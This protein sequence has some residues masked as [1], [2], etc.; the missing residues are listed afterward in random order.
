MQILPFGDA[1]FGISIYRKYRG[2]TKTEVCCSALCDSKIIN[3]LAALFSNFSTAKKL[4]SKECK[5][6]PQ[7]TAPPKAEK[8]SLCT[9]P[10]TLSQN[11]RATGARMG[12]VSK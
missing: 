4:H 6:T 8:S 1:D 5:C 9:V 7:L 11:R 2:Y 3:K 12:L 10:K